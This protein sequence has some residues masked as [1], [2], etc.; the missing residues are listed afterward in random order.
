MK[1]FSA[2]VDEHIRK[3]KLRMNAIVKT[4]AQAVVEDANTPTARGGRMPV[5]TS[6]LRNS[7]VAAIGNM[8]QGPADPKVDGVGDVDT[9]ALVI[10]QM[11]PGQIL[12]AGWSANYARPMEARYGFRDAA[13]QKW[14]QRVAAAVAEVKRRIP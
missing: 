5:D 12:Y 1:A 13:V 3:C 11:Q 9:V 4:A 14:P 7:I 2:S 10:A 8:P 6:F